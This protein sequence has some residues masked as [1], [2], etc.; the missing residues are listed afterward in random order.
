MTLKTG[1]ML[2]FCVVQVAR[3]TISVA[4]GKAFK[5]SSGVWITSLL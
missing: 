3:A 2:N 4:K 5:A 1:E